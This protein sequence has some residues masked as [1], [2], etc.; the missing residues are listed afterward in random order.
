[1]R[2]KHLPTIRKMSDA[3]CDEIKIMLPSEKPDK[4]IEEVPSTYHQKY[5]RYSLRPMNWMSIENASRGAW[6]RLYMS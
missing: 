6:F 1:M 4:T 5:R 3:L 2:S